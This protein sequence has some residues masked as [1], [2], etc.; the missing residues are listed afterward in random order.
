MAKTFLK[1]WNAALI[2]F[3]LIFLIHILYFTKWG[4]I[5][6][7]VC[8]LCMYRYSFCFPFLLIML[9]PLRFILWLHVGVPTS[10]WEP[11]V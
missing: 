10:Y 4:N 9:Q 6:C 2:T 3:F 7:I 5:L 1:K 11:L 8:V